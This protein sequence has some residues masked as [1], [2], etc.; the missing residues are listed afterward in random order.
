MALR[1]SKAVLTLCIGVFALLAG[2]GNILDYDT[3]FEF[4]RHV[5]SMDTTFPNNALLWR[6]IEDERLHHLAY[7]I[8]IGAELLTG[9][10]CTA[11]AVRLYQNRSAP[12][13]AFA[14]AKC[15]AIAGLV[16]GFVLYFFGFLA[17]G[18]EWFQM[19]QSATWNG[20]QPAF[21]LAACIGVVLI[22]LALEDRDLA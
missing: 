22:F 19:W 5:L 16:C 4:V 3:N 12:A 7:L 21:R 9:A 2:T 1:L 10:L 20:Q 14:K 13:G 11:G 17:V 6:R 18:G 8:I 15:T